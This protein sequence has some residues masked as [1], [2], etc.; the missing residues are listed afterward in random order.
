MQGRKYTLQHS[1]SLFTDDRVFI[2]RTCTLD[3]EIGS[4]EHCGLKELRID[5]LNDGVD[6][7]VLRNRVCGRRE[8]RG[9]KRVERVRASIVVVSDCVGDLVLQV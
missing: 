4:A 2:P 5:V 7:E 8:R 6:I 1:H 3:S 9:V